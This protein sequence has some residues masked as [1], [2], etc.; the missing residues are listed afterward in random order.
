MPGAGN[1]LGAAARQTAQSDRAIRDAA[2]DAERAEVVLAKE[3]GVDK[4]ARAAGN[5]ERA[6]GRPGVGGKGTGAAHGSSPNAVEQAARLPGVKPSAPRKLLSPEVLQEAEDLALEAQTEQMGS[7]RMGKTVAVRE[8]GVDRPIF[9]GPGDKRRPA[10]LWERAAPGGMSEPE[11]YVKR[12]EELSGERPRN[13]GLDTHVQGDEYA[14]HAE[15]KDRIQQIDRGINKKT[16]VS[17]D[18]CPRCRE[19]FPRTAQ[20]QNMRMTVSD[21]NHTRHFHPDGTVDIYKAGGEHIETVPAGR[22]VSA[23]RKNYM[24]LPW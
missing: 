3:K 1:P 23:T 8:G 24:G 20:R 18:M 21:I 17:Q 5:A 16:G 7:Y 19:W 4:N 14:T 2:N 15:V 6:V 10:W 13:S 22:P 9:S 12:Y 11:Y